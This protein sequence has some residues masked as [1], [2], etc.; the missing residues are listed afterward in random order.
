MALSV[1]QLPDDP[2]A[3]KQL[4]IGREALITCLIE[5]ITR[6]KRWRFGRSAEKIDES[7]S[8]QLWLHDLPKIEEPVKPGPSIEQSGSVP[9]EDSTD[10][11]PQPKA[12]GTRERRTARSL[13]ADLPRRTVVHPPRSCQC[14]ECG[15]AMRRLGEDISEMLDFVPGH[16]EVVRHVRPKLS[17]AHCSKVVQHPAPARPIERALPTAGLLAHVL[18]S[19]YADHC[20]LYRQQGIYRRAGLELDRA[21]L[22]SWVGEASDLLDPVAAA[23]GRHVLAAQKIHGDD[24]PVPVLDPGRGRTK[25][26]RLWAYVRD[27]RPAAGPDPP[28]V[29]YRYSP[30]RKGEHPR[31]HLRTF[32][33]ILQADA[34]AG[35]TPLY[36]DGRILE[37]A[38]WAHSRRKYYDLYVV[39]RSPIAGEAIRR[40]GLLYAIEREIRGRAPELRAAVRQERSAPVLDALRPWLD[41]TLRNVSAKSPLAGAI[42]YTLVRWT[43]LTR[44]CADGRI[45]LDNNTA[46]RAIRP[47][48]LGRRNFLFAGSDAG[49]ERAANIYSLI[50][51]CLLNRIDPSTY[52]RHVLE[53]I[54]EHPINRIEE[55]LP[56]H[57]APKLT[58]P[59]RQAA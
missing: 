55:L 22:A 27:D 18:V 28:A 13:P 9:S 54:G 39:D 26:G 49:G 56:W 25:T 35:F 37:A 52:L 50:G 3:L 14:P 48:V 43:A 45:D 11:G 34:Y 1:D 12:S 32:R 29:W 33:G 47:L 6:L 20:P 2:E 17:C 59:Q 15:S 4:L 30:D 41:A 31:A 16:F 19:K 7:I 10:K 40:I 21:T 38:C 42:Q 53:C 36:E 24:T 57:I 23:V 5:E 51:T 44:F 58:A 8:P 46:E